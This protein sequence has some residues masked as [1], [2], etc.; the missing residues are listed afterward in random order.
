MCIFYK[1]NCSFVKREPLVKD[2]VYEVTGT[3]FSRVYSTENA[4]KE[5][6]PSRSAIFF[7]SKFTPHARF[8]HIHF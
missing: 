3:E 5:R 8:H 4:E 6:F 7:G 2:V 1:G